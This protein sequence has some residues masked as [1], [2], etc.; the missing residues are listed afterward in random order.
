MKYET[1]HEDID[2]S[3]N[4]LHYYQKAINVNIITTITDNKGIIIYANDKFCEISGYT[5]KELVGQTHKIVNS[6]YHSKAFFEN[7]WETISSGKLYKAEIRNKAKNGDYYWVDTV[8]I[9]VQMNNKIQYLSL[10]IV[11]TEKKELQEKNE[12][13]VKSLEGLLFIISHEVRAPLAS[14]LGLLQFDYSNV[15]KRDFIKALVYFKRSAEELDVL[16]KKLNLNLRD[17]RNRA[18]KGQVD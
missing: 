13:Y 10:R 6:N 12:E 8:I 14:I 16:L 1:F 7:L 5:R 3:E 2:D 15:S 18:K 11:I 17:I 4:W 9:P